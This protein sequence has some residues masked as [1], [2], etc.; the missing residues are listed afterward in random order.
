LQTG[1]RL[2]IYTLRLIRHLTA[3]KAHVKIKHEKGHQDN[4]SQVLDNKAILHVAAHNATTEALN[5]RSSEML[6][7]PEL[8]AQLFISN[9]LVTAHSTKKLCYAFH[10]I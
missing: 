1:C 7:L 3:L 2:H 9:K 6:Q 5:L 10:L 4:N 8:K